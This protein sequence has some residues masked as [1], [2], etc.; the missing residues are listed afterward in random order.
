ME[1]FLSFRAPSGSRLLYNYIRI[2]GVKRDLPDGFEKK[3]RNSKLF[4]QRLDEYA[5]LFEIQKIFRAYI[6]RCSN[7]TASQAMNLGITGLILE[8][9][10]FDL[11]KHDA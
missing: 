5:D 2:G 3:P 8:D 10:V 11:R 4:E 7:F 1:L 9:V 6:R